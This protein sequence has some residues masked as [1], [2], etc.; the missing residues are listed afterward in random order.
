MKVLML[1]TSLPHPPTSGGTLRV[2]NILREVASRHEVTLLTLQRPDE[3]A[4]PESLAAVREFAREVEV[5]PRPIKPSW[6]VRNALASL[7]GKIGRASCWGTVF[8]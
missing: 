4:T 1:T 3:A 6:K 8:I 7:L 2:W 5:V